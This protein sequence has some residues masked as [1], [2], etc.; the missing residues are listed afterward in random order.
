MVSVPFTNQFERK[1]MRWMNSSNPTEYA[2][3]KYWYLY[4]IDRVER[5]IEWSYCQH[6]SHWISLWHENRHGQDPVEL[7]SDFDQLN[8][9]PNSENEVED[10]K[11]SRWTPMVSSYSIWPRVNSGMTPVCWHVMEKSSFTDDA[12]RGSAT[13]SVIFARFFSFGKFVSRNVRRSSWTKPKKINDAFFPRSIHLPSETELMLSSALTPDWNGWKATNLTTVANFD[14]STTL[15]STC[16]RL[17][18]ISSNSRT[19]NSA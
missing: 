19:R 4:P 3:R 9:W 13:P 17:I 11:K 5:S 12:T 10:L 2:W 1:L 7:Y 15:A 6:D 18:P 14:R 8:L 16:G